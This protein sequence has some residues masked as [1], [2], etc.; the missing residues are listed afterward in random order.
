MILYIITVIRIILSTSLTSYSPTADPPGT[1]DRL[2]I[3][4]QHPPGPPH[5]PDRSLKLYDQAQ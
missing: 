2:W 1:W 5:P 3:C 4:S